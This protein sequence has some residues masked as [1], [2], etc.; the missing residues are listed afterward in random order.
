MHALLQRVAPL[1][2]ADPTQ[3]EL[4]PFLE[5]LSASAV[6]ARIAAPNY[7]HF[8][9][10]SGAGLLGYVALRDGQH[11]HHLFVQPEFHRRGIGRLLWQHILP[12]T[13]QA[14]ITVNSSLFAVPTYRSFGFEPHGEPQLKSHPPYVPMVHPGGI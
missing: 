4:A 3:P 12:L 1:M 10:E 9:A 5:S 2:V 13:G 7:R 8:I 6:L 14:P 11:L